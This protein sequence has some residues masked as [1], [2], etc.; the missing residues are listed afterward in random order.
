VMRFPVMPRFVDAMGS[1]LLEVVVA[2]LL[3]G[4]L[5]VPLATAFGGAVGQTRGA[6]VQAAAVGADGRGLAAA[7]S[8]EWGPRVIAGWWRPGPILHLKLSSEA[9]EGAEAGR[10]VGLWVDGWLK[11]ELSVE[12]GSSSDAVGGPEEVR[13]GP[14][15][16]TGLSGGELTVRVRTADGTWGPPWRLAVPGPAADPPAPGSV[17][18]DPSTEPSVAAHRPAA[19]TSSLT[20]SWSADGLSSPPFGAPFIVVARMQGWGAAVLD[21]RSQWWWMEDGRSVDLYF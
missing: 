13:I 10:R 15:P 7:G 8:W 18:P 20:A 12:A 3:I 6:R 11:E 5:V 1:V 16:W 19:G 21:Q 17:L 9:V 4:M 14:D 2:S